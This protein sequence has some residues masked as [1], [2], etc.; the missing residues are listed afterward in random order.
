LILLAAPQGLCPAACTPLRHKMNNKI[1]FYYIGYLCQNKEQAQTFFALQRKFGQ[2][3]A[4]PEIERNTGR[5]TAH[6]G[7]FCYPKKNKCFC[8]RSAAMPQRP[9]C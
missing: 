2:K 7:A 5:R 9:F 3:T 8:R 1:Q 4:L 6:A